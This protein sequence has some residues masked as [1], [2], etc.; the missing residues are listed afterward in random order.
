MIKGIFI[1][2]ACTLLAIPSASAQT[3]TGSLPFSMARIQVGGDGVF[4]SNSRSIVG[5]ASAGNEQYFGRVGANFT[6]FSGLDNGAKGIFVAGGAEF[7]VDAPKPLSVCP[8]VSIAKAW[9]P[10]PGPDFDFSTVAVQIG[11][12]V[13]FVAAKTPQATIVPTVAVSFNHV[14]L[15]TNGNGLFQGGTSGDSFMS[16]GLGAGVIFNDKFSLVPS[17]LIP[18]H[19]DTGETAFSIYF[20]TKIGS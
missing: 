7:N 1:A 3:C 2:A 12:R 11:A 13:G 4:S 8:E 17:V 16:L 14:S 6:S 15:S 5:E 18:I 19:Y 9:G 20:A 10:S